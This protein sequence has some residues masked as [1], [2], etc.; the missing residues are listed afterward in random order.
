MPATTPSIRLYPTE[1]RPSLPVRLVARLGAFLAAIW[2]ESQL[3]RDQRLLAHLDDRALSD[4]GL[5][6][7]EIEDV[8]RVGR[9]QHAAATSSPYSLWH[10]PRTVRRTSL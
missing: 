10:G 1:D 2:R 5:G 6:R 4:L 3:R 9:G 8:V 7:S